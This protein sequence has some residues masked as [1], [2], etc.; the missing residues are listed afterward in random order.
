MKDK[1]TPIQKDVDEIM[2]NIPEVRNTAQ[3]ANPI[4][5]VECAS[6]F[7]Q[8]SKNFWMQLEGGKY[9][10]KYNAGVINGTYN[11]Q[12]PNFK[13]M[14]NIILNAYKNAVADMGLDEDVKTDSMNLY[15]KNMELSEELFE[16]NI[17]K[18]FKNNVDGIALLSYIHGMLNNYINKNITKD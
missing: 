4:K 12:V 2:E 16:E 15:F 5:K 3:L 6:D 18:I 1:P 11:S 8:P 10:T 14:F 9:L 13:S 17:N 7:M